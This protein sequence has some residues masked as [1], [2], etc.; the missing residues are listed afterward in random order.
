MQQGDEDAARAGAEIDQAQ[1]PRRFGKEPQACLHQRLGVGPRHQRLGGEP[2]RQTPEL[3]SADDARHRL[4]G[5][6]F[7]GGL[8]ERVGAGFAKGGLAL[9]D[10]FGRGQPEGMLGEEAGVA[11]RVGEAG[12][13]EGLCEPAQGFRAGEGGG[14]G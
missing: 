10:Q 5:E 13:R 14:E 1:G 12:G 6:S 8:G 3:P 11:P 7:R 2:D 4:A 9:Q